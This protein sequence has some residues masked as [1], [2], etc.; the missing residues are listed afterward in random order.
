MGNTAG[1]LLPRLTVRL[2]LQRASFVDFEVHTFEVRE[3]AG[4]RRSPT[5]L[6]ARPHAGRRVVEL[7]ESRQEAEVRSCV[8]G[9]RCS[10]PG[11]PGHGRWPRRCR[12]RGCP[13]RP[14]RE[15]GTPAGARSSARRYRRAESSVCSA[16][17]RIGSVADV[18]GESVLAR[19][20]DESTGRNRDGRA[21]CAPWARGAPP[22]T[23]RRAGRVR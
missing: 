4:M 18:G 16:G 21:N 23:A 13:P 19:H 2:R 10:W 8:L 20:R 7:R 6:L 9:A 15:V 11:N 3:E 22:R 12:G 14:P 5:E 1:P 17:Q